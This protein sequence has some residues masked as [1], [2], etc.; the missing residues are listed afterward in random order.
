M[1]QFYVTDKESSVRARDSVPLQI[2]IT[3]SGTIDDKIGIFTG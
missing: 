3:M 2:P 1:S